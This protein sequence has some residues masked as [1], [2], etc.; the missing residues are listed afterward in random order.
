MN[1][2]TVGDHDDPQLGLCTPP[3]CTDPTDPPEQTDVCVNGGTH[4]LVLSG[5]HRGSVHD[6]TPYPNDWGLASNP[7]LSLW[8]CLM[9]TGEQPS[10][11]LA[12]N[13]AIQTRFRVYFPYGK[14]CSAPHTVNT[15]SPILLEDARHHRTALPHSSHQVWW[16]WHLVVWG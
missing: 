14:V 11:P 5:C 3:D 4:G 10:P 16:G 2:E 12:S 7:C 8:P 15:Y 9:A 13:P 1:I 6:R